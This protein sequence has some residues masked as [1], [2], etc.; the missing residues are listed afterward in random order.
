MLAWR[1]RVRPLPARLERRPKV[2]PT[3]AWIDPHAV[4]A[5]LDAYASASGE[6]PCGLLLGRRRGDAAWIDEAIAL[7]NVHAEPRRAFLLDPAGHLGAARDARERGLE[8]LGTWHG[9]LEGPPYPGLADAEGMSAF[10]AIPGDATPGPAL[11]AIVGRGT[12]GRA[13]L[14]VF[15]P[16]PDGPR[17]IP[18]RR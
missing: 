14:R 6:E 10:R 8:V 4:R 1:A 12:T 16:G 2:T 11:L 18:L 5:L 13:V 17:E 9:H 7:R 3:K 15:A